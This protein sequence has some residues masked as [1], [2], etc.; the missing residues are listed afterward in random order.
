M[1]HHKG[2]AIFVNII[3]TVFLISFL[4]SCSSPAEKEK[5]QEF[6][7]LKEI[8]I[9]AILPL[10]GHMNY[11][12]ENERKAIELAAKDKNS[13]YNR[14]I[15]KVLFEDSKE[16]PDQAENIANKLMNVD[17]VSAFVTSSYS[18]SNVVLPIANKNKIII[19]MLCTDSD[20]QKESPYAFRLYESMSSEAN[21]LLE[22]YSTTK[23]KKK[24]VVFYL[25]HPDIVK[26]VT[27]FLI[28]GFMQD[29]IK[30]VYYEP[31]DATEKDFKTKIERLKHSG[32]NSLLIIGYS[33]EH[34]S[35]FKELVRQGLLGKIEIT[36]GWG[37]I[38][39]NNVPANLLEGTIVAGPKYFFLKNEKAKQ[40]EDSFRKKYGYAPDLDTTF[41]YHGMNILFE[42]LIYGLIE[43]KGNSD[44]VSHK[45]IN[46]IHDGVMG[47]VSIDIYGGLEVPMGL[48]I[49]R[50]G[51]IVPY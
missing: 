3:V 43:K 26:E 38:M 41:A 17:E 35:L 16:S 51:K 50:Q 24:V 36:G 6:K 25:N 32:A 28:P 42:G 12:G 23:E 46:S 39:P 18:I 1:N 34:D 49:I 8:K 15:I 29:K 11:L 21:Q 30:V 40:F 33:S 22:Y 44:T 31:Y 37:F 20:I 45:L 5:E 14:E 2:A 27:V 10:T 19:A 7:E 13:K 9:G 4:L 48:G 47:E